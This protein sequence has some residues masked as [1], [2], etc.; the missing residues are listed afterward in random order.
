MVLALISLVIGALV[1]K[2]KI[3][4]WYIFVPIIIVELVSSIDTLY[5]YFYSGRTKS[6]ETS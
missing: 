4:K 1:V 5:F 2:R 3:N 6:N